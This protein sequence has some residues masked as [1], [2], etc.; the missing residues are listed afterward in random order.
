MPNQ[1]PP[2]AA[3]AAT[4]AHG[5][6]PGSTAYRDRFVHHK[7]TPERVIEAINLKGGIISEV[8]KALNI[9]RGTLYNYRDQFPEVAEAL[10]E[11]REVHLDAAEAV[12]IDL[13]INQKKERSLH[14]FLEALGKARGYVKRT[15]TVGKDGG[16]IEHRD[17]TPEFTDAELRA[18]EP[19]ELEALIAAEKVKQNVRTRIEA[20]REAGPDGGGAPVAG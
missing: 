14:F 20:A 3:P 18:M 16:P 6:E 10:T 1:S 5:L 2:E 17:S 19:A 9:S 12:L 4:S 7:L 13:A 8:A 15:E 11:V